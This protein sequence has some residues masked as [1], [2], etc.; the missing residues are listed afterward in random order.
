MFVQL[1]IKAFIIK[2]KDKEDDHRDSM[3]K[4]GY[5]VFNGKY[6]AVPMHI[7]G[8]DKIESSQGGGHS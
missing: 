3:V 1:W 2:E 8:H 6:G 7:N 5:K 4:S